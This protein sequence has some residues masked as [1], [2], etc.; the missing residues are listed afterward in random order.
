MYG[1]VAQLLRK[2][3]YDFKIPNTNLTIP[4]GTQV[5]IPAYA[6]HM[7][8]DIYPDP[9]KFDPE[10][11]SVENK[12]NRHPMAFLAFGEGPRNCI[13]E[14]FGL[15][16]TKIAIIK[17]ITNFKF[18]TTSRTPIPMVFD[19]KNLIISPDGND[20]WLKLEKL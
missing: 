3:S 1:P 15:M 11:F 18:S 20:M 4:K 2:A 14:R 19:K 17:L 16:Q 7:D 13:G 10:R 12:R 9:D 6:V 8:P 5:I